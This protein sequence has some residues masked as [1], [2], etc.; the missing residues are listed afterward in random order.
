MSRSV[1]RKRSSQS[2][3]KPNAATNPVIRYLRLLVRYPHTPESNKAQLQFIVA[4]VLFSVVFS[5]MA[6]M[7]MISDYEWA[8]VFSDFMASFIP[9]IDKVT[10]AM[11]DSHV[12]RSEENRFYFSVMWALSPICILLAWQ[13]MMAGKRF[14]PALVKPTFTR[15]L[16]G[17]LIASFSLVIVFAFPPVGKD[18]L[19][20][21]NLTNAY[22]SNAFL[23]GL[24]AVGMV[25]GPVVGITLFV[26]QL[27]EGL[28]DE[29]LSWKKLKGE[30]HGR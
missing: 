28:A 27:K 1:R 20:V 30:R 16:G 25:F 24:G 19:Y 14:D 8:R 13:Q 4:S 21:S 10:I 6:P 5:A 11:L 3:Q 22:L 2:A 29:L 7:R 23:R 18:G 15:F 9:M 26:F 17:L 12:N